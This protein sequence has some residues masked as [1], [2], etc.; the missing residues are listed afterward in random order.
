M[1]I[2]MLLSGFLF[3][4]ILVINLIMA[5]FGYKMEKEEYDPDTDLKK[6][7]NNP[8]KFKTGIVL[9][10]I[11]HSSVIALTALLFITFSSYNIILGIIWL[12][13]RT[14][15]GLIQFINEPNY[16]KLLKIAKQYSTSSNEKESLSNKAK[17]IFKTKDQRFK[18]AMICWSI[19]TSAF[20]IVLVLSGIVPAIIGWLGIVASILVGFTTSIKLAK[21]KSKDFTAAG[22]L[23]AIL[24]E[25]IIG[26]ALIYY[27]II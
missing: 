14:A 16:W 27:S 12:I 10:V 21:P 4:F 3:L 8:K 19:G 18:I 11:E 24:F 2:E 22:G 15:E 20:S 23:L 17:S 26:I 5:S 25:V 9:A 6:I 1:I 13:F 7:N